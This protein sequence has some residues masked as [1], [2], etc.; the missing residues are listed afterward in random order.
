V[1]NYGDRAVTID[2]AEESRELKPL[3]HGDVL[4]GH[5]YPL[6][7]FGVE[8]FFR[9]INKRLSLYQ[10]NPRTGVDFFWGRWCASPGSPSAPAC[11]MLIVAKQCDLSSLSFQALS[12]MFTISCP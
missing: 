3:L 12:R 5:H 2:L 9:E 6:P 8:V 11:R 1:Q 7:A 10:K 4:R